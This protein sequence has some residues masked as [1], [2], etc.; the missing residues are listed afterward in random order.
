M[1]FLY[2]RQENFPE[3]SKTSGHRSSTCPNIFLILYM[4]RYFSELIDSYTLENVTYLNTL[5][6]LK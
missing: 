5:T 1:S 2:D 4:S 3:L 6:Y